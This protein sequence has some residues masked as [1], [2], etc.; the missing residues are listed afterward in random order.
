M[1]VL[2]TSSNL[3]VE[4]KYTKN[5]ISAFR[6]LLPILMLFS[7]PFLYLNKKL[8]VIVETVQA[9]SEVP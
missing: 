5:I 6:F 7:E 8:F 3:Q 4:Q 2:S 9:F 1:K